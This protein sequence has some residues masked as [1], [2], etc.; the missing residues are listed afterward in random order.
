MSPAFLQY[1]IIQTVTE[2]EG[3]QSDSFPL[4]MQTAEMWRNDKDDSWRTS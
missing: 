3:E 1:R 4:E 2:E